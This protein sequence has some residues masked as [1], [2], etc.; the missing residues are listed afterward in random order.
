MKEDS[1]SK[2]PFRGYAGPN[3]TPVPDELFDEQLPDLTGAELK[4]LLY[5][6]RRTFGFKRDSDNISLSQMLNGLRTRDGRVLDRGVGLTKKT[7]L[8]A[9]KSLEE[10]R[11]IL[12]ERRRSLERGDEPTSYRLNVRATPGGEETTLPVGEK[13]R[14][15]GGGESPPGPWGKNYPTQ[16]T[17]L[18]ETDLD[19]SRF[20]GPHGC[21]DTPENGRRHSPG[22]GRQAS[23][24][25]PAD[26]TNGSRTPGEILPERP[27]VA[28][29]SNGR[30]PARRRPGTAPSAGSTEEREKL[31]AYLRDFGPELGDEASLPASITQVLKIF[32]A[33]RTPLAHW[34]DHLYRARALTQERTASITK[35]GNGAA[36]PRRKNKFPYFKAVLRD[37]VGPED[38]DPPATPAADRRR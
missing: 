23:P 16:E 26:E 2:A 19:L 17:G 37:L 13:I 29:S 8:Q 22:R 18:Q 10:Q 14:H 4:V 33:A 9:I 25:E 30:P 5:I 15:G 38:R 11:I 7:L 34:D 12:T 21:V 6:I 20:D 1:T 32:R 36:G 28:D 31:A 3:Y 35:Q 24:T 27:P